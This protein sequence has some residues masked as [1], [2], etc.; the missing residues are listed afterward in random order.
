MKKMIVSNRP[1]SLRTLL[2]AYKTKK[3]RLKRAGEI[4]DIEVEWKDIKLNNKYIDKFNKICNL[5]K[6]NS[7]NILYPFTMMYP[8]NLFLISQKEIRVPMFKMLTIR[9]TTT[10]YKDIEKNAK[11]LIRSRSN[12]KNYIKNGMEFY[13]DSQIESNGETVWENR[14]TLF[15][16]EKKEGA[17]Q[18]YK[19]H[20]LEEIP[21]AEI[22]K[23]WFLPA[24]N[25]LGFARIMGDSNG[26]HYS[27]RYARKL[28][29]KRDFAQPVL[30]SS[31]CIES[32]PEISGDGPLKLD[33]FFKG[34]VYFNSE[35]TQKNLFEENSNRFDLYCEG[36]ERPCISGKLERI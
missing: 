13:I 29:F 3:H 6:K 32:L 36:N 1:S 7:L 20:K 4:D 17:D 9:N 27:K 19:P 15:I 31:K 18:N 2:K 33:L 5:Q 11:L 16:P 10:T 34:P 22:L 14:S 30:V 35:L 26:I 21:D 24:K 25:R 8:L 12:G 28:G 23:K